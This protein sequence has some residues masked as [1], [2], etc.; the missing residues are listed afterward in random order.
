MAE[1]VDGRARSGGDGI[2]DGRD[3]LELALDRVGRPVAGCA[4]PAPV[5][6]VDREVAGEQRSDDPE[7]R[8][9]GGRAMD[10]DRSAVRRRG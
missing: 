9:I 4:P 2:G 3:I 1:D 6:R 5:D 10:E 7:R 8:V